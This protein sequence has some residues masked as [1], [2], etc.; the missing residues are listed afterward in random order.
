MANGFDFNTLV[1]PLQRAQGYPHTGQ[2]NGFGG[3]AAAGAITLANLAATLEAAAAQL[4]ALAPP[5]CPPVYIDTLIVVM[6]P[7]ALAG[8]VRGSPGWPL[9]EQ[10]EIVL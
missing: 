5:S 1:N 9:A 6:D 4:R 8:L 3:P 2:Q 10:D 7:R